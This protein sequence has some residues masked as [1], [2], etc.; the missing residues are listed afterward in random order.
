MR[1]VLISLKILAFLSLLGASNAHSLELLVNGQT[2]ITKDEFI[3]GGQILGAK[4]AE[5]FNLPLGRNELKNLPIGSTLSF[6]PNNGP[7][8]F[9]TVAGAIVNT[10]I[11]NQNWTLISGREISLNCGRYNSSPA[12]IS[13]GKNN[14]LLSGCSTVGDQVLKT[15]TGDYV[16][17][18]RGSRIELFPNGSLKGSTKTMGRISV[19]ENQTVKL[20][21]GSSLR[22]HDNEKLHFFFPTNKEIFEAPTEIGTNSYFEQP[23]GDEAFPVV[24]HNN[25]Q[26]SSAILSGYNN[27]RV[28]FEAYGEVLNFYVQSGPVGFDE[29]GNIDRLYSTSGINLTVQKKTYIRKLSRETGST[30]VE[31]FDKGDTINIAPYTQLF[32]VHQTESKKVLSHYPTIETGGKEYM[33]ELSETPF[34]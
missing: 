20:K 7:D 17:A 9:L 33:N 14:Q 12:F 10:A 6:R 31:T 23:A 3:R 28:S 26:I 34:N 22:Y 1:K 21:D 11:P 16:L 18:R 8:D 30:S 24:F 2:V 13:L 25:G 32:L 27:Y 29:N 19:L 5:K 15:P 4:T